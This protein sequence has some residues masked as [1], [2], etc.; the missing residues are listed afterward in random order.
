MGS[1][2]PLSIS[3]MEPYCYNKGDS[4]HRNGGLES[5]YTGMLRIGLEREG[6]CPISSS[7][8]AKKALF[9]LLFKGRDFRGER[10]KP[11]RA[12]QKRLV[13]GPAK[14]SEKGS[15]VCKHSNEPR[16]LGP[17]WDERGD[18]KYK[19]SPPMHVPNA[20]TGRCTFYQGKGRGEKS[21]LSSGCGHTCADCR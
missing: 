13:G 21:S 15:L 12:I 10:S 8:P 20:H 5:K 3:S 11:L 4:I 16:T 9:L 6:K 1:A 7:G 19:P 14:L 17:V 2:Q 18:P